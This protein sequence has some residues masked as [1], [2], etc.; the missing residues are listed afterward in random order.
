MYLKHSKSDMPF[1]LTVH[2]SE[3]AIVNHSDLL[4][5]LCQMVCDEPDVYLPVG[6]HQAHTPVLHYIKE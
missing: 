1:T 4:T 2:L 3:C 6:D 5:Q